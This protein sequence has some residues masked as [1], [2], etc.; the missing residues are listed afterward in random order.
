MMADVQDHPWH[1][2]EKIAKLDPEREALLYRPV[3]PRSESIK[4]LIR[5]LCITLALALCARHLDY[6]RIALV[7]TSVAMINA[8]RGFLKVKRGVNFT[9]LSYEEL[10]TKSQ[11]WAAKIRGAGVSKGD[12]LCVMWQPED[13]ADQAAFQLALMR[14]GITVINTA[15]LSSFV[16]WMY[17]VE[18]QLPTVI[19][20]THWEQVI[21]RL[22]TLFGFFKSVKR[23]VTPGSLCALYEE[24]KQ[25]LPEL[26][27]SDVLSL[28]PRGSGEAMAVTVENCMA[29]IDCHEALLI[30]VACVG[31]HWTAL[32][33][34][35]YMCLLDIASGATAVHFPSHPSAVLKTS[36]APILKV[37]ADL[38]ITVMDQ[39]P[40]VWH[41]IAQHLVGKKER[42]PSTFV[43]AFSVGAEVHTTAR[44]MLANV[45]AG[46]PTF[47]LHTVHAMPQAGP[48][49]VLS[50][51]TALSSAVIKGMLAGRGICIGE[52]L[53][54]LSAKVLTIGSTLPG[55]VTPKE[56]QTDESGFLAIS[57]AAF[58]LPTSR[59]TSQHLQSYVKLNQV[60]YFVSKD[61][62]HIDGD[63]RIWSEGPVEDAVI[64]GAKRI[65]CVSVESAVQTVAAV[66]RAVFVDIP[67]KGPVL[68]LE[69]AGTEKWTT[70][71]E[72]E[73][74]EV[75]RKAERCAVAKDA[76][77]LPFPRTQPLPVD[78]V[79]C[80]KV[81]RAA[82]V[83]W[84][85]S[86]V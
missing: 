23:R 44:R 17:S 47:A 61:L 85:S 79:F 81:D 83:K 12:V 19:L 21:L 75:L 43:A 60:E 59:A 70:T 68:V 63:G 18:A 20:G 8:M 74:R 77:M 34:N 84:A 22:T 39:P 25:P 78:S 50:D 14:L 76:K 53:D 80:S 38:S 65:S 58:S 13:Y 41:H 16:Q 49:A 71:I 37:L 15:L 73:I 52:V 55:S 64:I 54:E 62:V 7:L 31:D 29:Q 27:L 9:T 86:R 10:W 1:R 33:S 24:E 72:D 45:S 42:L 36:P 4:G 6:S 82:V 35:M 28:C 46:A 26:A 30:E 11:E 5:P 2:V 51:E 40:A 69:Q 66:H 32:R 67:A 3:V 57:G 56:A 48:V